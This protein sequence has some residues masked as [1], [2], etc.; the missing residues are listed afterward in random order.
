MKYPSTALADLAQLIDHCQPD[1]LLCVGEMLNQ[2]DNIINTYCLQREQ[3]LKPCKLNQAASKFDITDAIYTQRYDLAVVSATLENIDKYQAQQLISRLRD[4]CTPKLVVLLNLTASPWE[5]AD[6]LAF[7]LV[8]ISH[9]SGNTELDNDDS[10][11][12]LYHYN[13]DSYKNTP[14]WLNAKNWANPKLWN[15]VWW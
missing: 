10:E 13:I 7:G 8:R 3:I 6:L 5:V 1:T 2:E 4:L 15:K 12:G 9:Y 11:Y 14:D